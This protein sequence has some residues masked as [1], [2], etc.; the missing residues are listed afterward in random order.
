MFEGT[1]VGLPHHIQ[2]TDSAREV[3]ARARHEALRLGH[4]YIGTEHLVLALTSHTQG[5][6]ANA[7]RNQHIDL[8]R[9]R[10]TIESIIR[11][12]PTALSP[13]SRVAYTTRT[14]KVFA[15]ANESAST[16]ARSEVGA[17]HLLI[18]ILRE[19]AGI[20]G[21]VI[22]QHGLSAAAAVDEIRRLTSG[23]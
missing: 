5:L 3:L 12:G 2:F 19:A 14:K 9:V 6:V 16:F 18:G 22:M 13:E 15:L 10:G 7:L 11:P 17:E 20:G 8:E 21:Q 4:E 23:T 1:D